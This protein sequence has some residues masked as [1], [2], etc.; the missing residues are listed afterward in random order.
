MSDFLVGEQQWI[1]YNLSNLFAGEWFEIASIHVQLRRGGETERTLHRTL[2]SPNM[3]LCR[4]I[5]CNDI[6]VVGLPNLSSRS[7]LCIH[8]SFA[9]GVYRGQ[10]ILTRHYEPQIC[11]CWSATKSSDR[12][13]WSFCCHWRRWIAFVSVCHALALRSTSV[14]MRAFSIMGL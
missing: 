10:P 11:F 4:S 2:R 9:F 5:T 14:A 6:V 13:V 8:Y 12:E 1:G 7:Y 3:W